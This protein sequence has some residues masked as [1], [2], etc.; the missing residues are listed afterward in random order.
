MLLSDRSTRRSQGL[1]TTVRL[2]TVGLVTAA[3]LMGLER[4]A[5]ACSCPEPEPPAVAAEE[6]DAVFAGEIVA[7]DQPEPGRFDDRSGVVAVH[8][9]WAGE[10]AE[11]TPLS[12]PAD[13]GLCGIEPQVG[14]EYLVYARAGDDGALVTDLCMRTTQLER[15]DEDLAALGEPTDPLPSEPGDRSTGARSGPSIAI[16]AALWVGAAAGAAAVVVAIAI[17]QRRRPALL[18]AAVLFLPIG[19]YGILS[20]GALFLAAALACVIAAV[21]NPGGKPASP[22]PPS[23]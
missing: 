17:P 6:A 7:F 19:I 13:Q 8:S 2:L 18:A 9:V 11:E 15:A 16:A 4:T 5:E 3:A 21:V 20:V 10:I 22:A 23:T 14:E 12:T 1:P